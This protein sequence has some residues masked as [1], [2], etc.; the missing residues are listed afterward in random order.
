MP[1][2]KRSKWRN[3][4]SAQVLAMSNTIGQ[5]KAA[6][7][8][9]GIDISCLTIEGTGERQRETEVIEITINAPG[10]SRERVG[11]L[12]AEACDRAS[13]CVKL[14]EKVYGEHVQSIH[15]YRIYWVIR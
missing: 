3:L 12:A 6:L 9:A 10:I 8:A 14:A 2:D 15:G 13:I 5:I 11:K 1:Q 4:S 7:A